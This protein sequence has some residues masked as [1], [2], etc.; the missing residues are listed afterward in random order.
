[1]RKQ[2]KAGLVH[3]YM[4]S[5]AL[6]CQVFFLFF[7]SSPEGLNAATIRRARGI[8]AYAF[9]KVYFPWPQCPQTQ[10]LCG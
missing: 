8:T 4:F 5:L 6:G 9:G 7:K 1:M 2:I 10:V 3:A